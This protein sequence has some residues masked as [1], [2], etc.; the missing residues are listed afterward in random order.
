MNARDKASLFAMSFAFL[1]RFAIVEV[2]IPDELIYRELFAGWLSGLPGEEAVPLIEAA[3][4]LAFGPRQLGPA[5]LKDIAG[6]TTMGHTATETSSAFAPYPNATDA[7]LTATRLYAAPQYEGAPQAEG[8][9]LLSA[10]RGSLTDPPAESWSALE[11]A[12]EDLKL[13]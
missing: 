1:R 7:F 3:M 6:F 9:T 11:R 8:A 4:E 5:I 10:L 13:S 2:P 12:I